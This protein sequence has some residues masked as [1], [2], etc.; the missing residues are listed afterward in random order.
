EAAVLVEFHNAGISVSVADKDV[1]C[2]VP[3]DVGWTV[4]Y[5]R[6][7]FQGRSSG[8]KAVHHFRPSAEHHYDAAFRIEL[9]DHVRSFTHAPD[10]VVAVDADGMRKFEPVQSG[11]DLP[12][13]ITVLIELE[14]PGIAASRVD[15]NVP[16]G[17]CGHADTFA[18][19]QVWRQFQEIRN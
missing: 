14:Q 3:T 1:A 17:V 5:V 15:E 9:D 11:A 13:V 18:Q 8:G 7:R 16:F 4:E 19:I 6:L 10:V 12:D 2:G